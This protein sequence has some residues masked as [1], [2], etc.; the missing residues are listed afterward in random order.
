VK[1]GPG[2]ALEFFGSGKPHGSV[3][4]ESS[5]DLKHWQTMQFLS[6]DAA[7]ELNFGISPEV[8]D[9]GLFYRL[10]EIP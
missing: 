7:G 2:A 9:G 4:F 10:V 5:L 3:R 8:P 6:L 1:R